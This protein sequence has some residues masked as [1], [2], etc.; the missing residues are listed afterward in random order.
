MAKVMRSN[1]ISLHVF[2]HNKPAISMYDSLGY[3]ATNIIMKK[4]LENEDP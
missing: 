2:G 3:C 1:S 4:D